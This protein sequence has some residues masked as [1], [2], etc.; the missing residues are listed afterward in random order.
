LIVA[1]VASQLFMIFDGSFTAG[2]GPYNRHLLPEKRNQIGA[3]LPH[4]LTMMAAS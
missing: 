4:S 3:N 2:L 1:L